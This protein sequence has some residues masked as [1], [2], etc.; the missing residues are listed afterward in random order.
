VSDYILDDL[1]TGISSPAEAKDISSSLC[2]QTGS[3]TYPASYPTGTR[4]PF[5]RGKAQPG[6][7]ADHS[8]PSSAEI[9]N[10]LEPYF[11]SALLP[12]W[13]KRDSFTTHIF[14]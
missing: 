7:D 8:T 6:R 2:V 13:L 10:E 3:E 9:K 1:V 5:Q 11:L 4:G 12:A 14:V